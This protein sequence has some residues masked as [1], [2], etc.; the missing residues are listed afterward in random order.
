MAAWASISAGL[1]WTL[2][3]VHLMLAHGP[4]EVNEMR[5]VLGL[6]WIDSARLVAPSLALTGV[7]MWALA[8]WHGP[9]RVAA[10]AVPGP[11]RWHCERAAVPGAPLLPVRRRIRRPRH[12][13][14]L[15]GG[16]GV[17][18]AMPTGCLV[19]DGRQ[20]LIAIAHGERRIQR[21]AFDLPQPIELDA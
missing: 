16:V 20:R 21:H 11:F 5:V 4:T 8:E 15:P 7:A 6:T 9:L 17:V 19:L 3:W 10:A 14:P 13:E 2:A 12:A 18:G 1:L